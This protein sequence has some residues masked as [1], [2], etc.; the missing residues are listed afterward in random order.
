M[1]NRIAYMDRNN[2]DRIKLSYFG[3]TPPEAYG[4]DYECLPAECSV[5]TGLGK[6]RPVLEIPTG[7]WIAVSATELQGVYFDDKHIYDWLKEHKP[8]AK[9][10]YSI[11]VYR[12]PE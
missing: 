2:I 7:G 8:V 9:I 1:A 4:I 11:F 3:S 6:S 12:L 10:G 5:T